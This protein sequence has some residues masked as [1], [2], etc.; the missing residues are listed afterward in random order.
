MQN[1]AKA[2]IMSNKEIILDKLKLFSLPDGGIGSWLLGETDND[3][4]E[5]LS[6]IDEE[7]LTRTQ[8]NPHFP[9]IVDIQCDEKA[10]LL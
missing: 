9:S 6:R 8:L 10:I 1:E 3:I 5:R 7:P 2:T 4:L